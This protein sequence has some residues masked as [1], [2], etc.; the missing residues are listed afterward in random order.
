MEER[1]KILVVDDEKGVREL[2]KQIL[3]DAGY[4]VITASDGEEA[5]LALSTES[6]H[7]MTLDIKMPVMSGM[8]VLARLSHDLP[9]VCLIMVTAIA[10]VSSAVEAMKLGALDYITKPFDREEVIQKIRRAIQA[11]H[12]LSQ[13]RESQTKLRDSITG[14]TDR[15]RQQFD[16]L[17][18]SL[19]REYRLLQQMAAQQPDKGKGAM[20]ELPPELRSPI[21]SFEEFRDALLRILRRS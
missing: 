12:Q 10:D 3:T 7:V 15:M 11:W 19:S 9:D 16:E 6:P 8:E 5:L 17:V 2:L 1:E 21:A 18:M 13:R 14:Q 20:S 4:E